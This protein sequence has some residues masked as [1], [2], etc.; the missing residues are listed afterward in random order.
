[1]AGTNGSI[2]NRLV[3]ESVGL[4]W[5]VHKALLLALRPQAD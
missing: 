5:Y 3:R 2:E 4:R 1:M